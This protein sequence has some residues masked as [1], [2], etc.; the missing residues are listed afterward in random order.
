LIILVSDVFVI[1]LF[2]YN[3]CAIGV[4]ELSTVFFT[5]S[6]LVKDS[7]VTVRHC[8]ILD[9][10]PAVLPLQ[11]LTHPKGS[12]MEVTCASIK[13]DK[14]NLIQ[15]NERSWFN[16]AFCVCENKKFCLNRDI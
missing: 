1:F 5:E 11:I 15:R 7:F 12:S 3:E 8:Y 9:T 14:C 16:S 6:S 10:K 4:H 2:N 13:L